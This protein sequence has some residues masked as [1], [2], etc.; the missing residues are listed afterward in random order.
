MRSS[1]SDAERHVIRKFFLH[2]SAK[3]QRQRFRNRLDEPE[4]KWKF[5]LGDL[6]EREHW[7]DYMGAY[8]TIRHTAT[9]HA[10]WMVVP[11]NRKWFARLVVAA[12]IIDAL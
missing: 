12:T 9:P 7:R 10:P 1:A 6:Q 3:E 11:W 2:I 5:S 8:E 4:K